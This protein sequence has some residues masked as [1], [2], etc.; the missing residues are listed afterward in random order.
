MR[1][2][3]VETN[4]ALLAEMHE[5][6]LNIIGL[7]KTYTISNF[8][9]FLR[10]ITK[11]QKHDVRVYP[12]VLVNRCIFIYM[13]NSNRLQGVFIFIFIK[14]SFVLNNIFSFLRILAT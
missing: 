2:V 10:S 12:L 1:T 4:R 3:R 5:K 9:F 14:I 11:C 8:Y 13:L 6:R 7:K